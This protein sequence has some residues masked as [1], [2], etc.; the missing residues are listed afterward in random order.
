[1]I[2]AHLSGGRGAAAVEPARHIALSEPDLSDPVARWTAVTALIESGLA[3]DRAS[4]PGLV[5]RL[6]SLADRIGAPSVLSETVRY[7][8]LSA[9][10]AQDPRDPKAALTACQEGLELARIVRD[11]SAEGINLSC[12]A[13]A[14]TALRAP[15][16]HNVCREA[17][18]RL[19]DMRFWILVWLVIETAA[20][21]FASAGRLREAAVVYGHLEA[22][23]SAWG[24]PAVRRSRERG[25]AKARQHPQESLLMVHGALMDRDRIVEYTLDQLSNPVGEDAPPASR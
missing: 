22:H 10:Y 14:A 8:A 4:V 3:N 15:D 13:F 18:A 5:E 17:L 21:S 25:L 6:T 1:V 19:Y 24:I 2:Q 16:A 9:L 20:G 7:K 12:L 23:R 11:L